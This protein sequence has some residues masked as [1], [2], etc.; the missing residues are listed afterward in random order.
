MEIL[1]SNCGKTFSLRQDLIGHDI[2]CPYCGHVVRAA[3]ISESDSKSAKGTKDEAD[4]KT[5]TT[6]QEEFPDEFATKAKLLLRKKLLVVCESCGKRLTVEQRLEGKTVRCPSCQAF[7]HVPTISAES[8]MEHHL[9]AIRAERE[10]IA[11]AVPLAAKS[12]G[13]TAPATPATTRQVRRSRSIGWSKWLMVIVLA[14]GLGISAVY[15]G[16]I[17]IGSSEDSNSAKQGVSPKIHETKVQENIPAT[18][19][20]VSTMP[21]RPSKPV[22]VNIPPTIKL[23]KTYTS[24]ISDNHIPAEPGKVFLYVFC[25]ISAGSGDLKISPCK[26]VFID[27]KEGQI[28][29]VGIYDEILALLQLARK[30]D[31]IIKARQHRRVK[32]VFVIPEGISMA[33]LKS[34]VMEN[35]L[36]PNLTKPF[37]VS[38]SGLVG[39]YIESGRYLKLEFDNPIMEKFRLSS[40]HYLIIRKCQDKYV[41][42]IPQLGISGIILQKDDDRNEYPV[43]LSVGGDT[44]RCRF[45]AIDS[46]KRIILYLSDKPYHQLIY[47]KKE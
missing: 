24:A 19:T 14:A 10:G 21:T 9:A 15:I 22:V 17:L 32:F 35:I 47:S 16:Y 36:L 13:N 40:R 44:L 8:A 1:C 18:R 46:G 4:V 29:S 7:V 5:E 30:D 28:P 39:R 12:T 45:R 23:I 11:E 42:F 3:L 33:M 37:S 26:D 6:S 25:G 31:F 41:M 27:C 20:A 34:K 2:R 38:L 43:I